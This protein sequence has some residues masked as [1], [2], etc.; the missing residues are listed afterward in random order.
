MPQGG[1]EIRGLVLDMKMLK[2]GKSIGKE[3][4]RKRG[5]DEIL[6]KMFLMD[7]SYASKRRRLDFFG[8]AS[9]AS[10]SIQYD[11]DFETDTFSKMQKLRLLKLSGIGITGCYDKFP[12][13]LRWLYWRGFPLTYIPNEFPL[14]SVVA[15]DMRNSSLTQFQNRINGV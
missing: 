3:D 11:L 9:K 15:L 5:P 13:G 8:N 10:S 12:K 14:E 2:D 6:E 7:Q 4:R 1:N